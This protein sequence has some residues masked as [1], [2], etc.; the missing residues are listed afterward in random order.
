MKNIAVGILV[1]LLTIGVKQ[2]SQPSL[3]AAR[4]CLMSAAVP[5][6]R[7]TCTAALMTT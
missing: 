5:G 7:P 1:S 4:F 6:N 2:G 3:A